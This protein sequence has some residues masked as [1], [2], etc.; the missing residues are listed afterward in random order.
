ML[1]SICIPTRNQPEAIYRLLETLKNEIVQDVEIVI[2]DGSDTYKSK[3][4]IYQYLDKLPIKYKKRLGYGIDEG[5]IELINISNGQYI[6]FLGDDDIVPG[7][8]QEVV[9][10][11]KKNNQVEYIYVNANCNRKKINT[12]RLKEKNFFYGKDELLMAAGSGLAFISSSVVK[13]SLAKKSLSYAKKYIGTDFVNFAIIMHIIANS[14][15]HYFL[16]KLLV[17]CYPHDSSEVKKRVTTSEGLINNNFFDIFGIAWNSILTDFE[18]AFSNEV[19]STI[20]KEIFGSTWRGVIVG[21][22]GGWDTPKGK[23]L[24]MIKTFYGYSEVWVALILFSLPKPILKYL[25]MLYKKG[26]F[27]HEVRL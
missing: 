13:S 14:E 8:V 21:Y 23:R 24:K 4:L 12:I 6:W 16:K 5:M 9:K 20:K 25:Y 19:T 17:I 18:S 1:L 3:Y 10:I 11:I 15:K 27:K 7:A 2:S 22:I 26:G